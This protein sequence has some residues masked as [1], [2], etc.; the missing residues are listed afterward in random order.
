MSLFKKYKRKVIGGSV[1]FSMGVVVP[2][3]ALLMYTLVSP[4]GDQLRVFIYSLVCAAVAVQ[5][6]PIILFPRLLN[7][8]EK[9]LNDLESGIEISEEFYHK[10]WNR[11]SKMPIW[12]ALIGILQWICGALIVLIPFEM[13]AQTTK[14]QSFYLENTFIFAAL[15]NV[16]LSF[17]F[18]EGTSSFLLQ[19]GAFD[20]ELEDNKKPFYRRL[21]ISIP[22]MISLMIIIMSDVYLMISYKI[23]SNSLEKAYSNQ[24]YNF[25]LSNEAS[26]NVLLANIES[27]LNEIAELPQIQE[28]MVK[29]NYTALTPILRKVYD[30]PSLYLENSIV[31]SVEDG[32]AVLATGLPDGTGIGYKLGTNPNIKENISHALEGKIHFGKVENSPIT[33]KL[34]IMVSAPIKA[35]GKVVGIL[36]LPMRMDDAIQDLLKNIKIGNTGYSF[37]LDR[38]SQ[39]VWHPNPKYLLVK[40]KDTEFETLSE[41]AGDTK[42]FVNNWEGSKFLLR[43]KTSS[44][45]GYQFYS[46]IDLAEI[47]KECYD[48]LDGLVLLSLSGA[49]LIALATFFVFYIKFKPIQGIES[50]LQNM[51]I[52][53]LTQNASLVSSDE[54]GKLAKGLNKT[55]LQV[56][57]VV[58]VNQAISDEMAAAAEQMSASLGSLSINSQTQAASAEEISASIEEISAAVQSVDSQAESQFKKVDYLKQQMNELTNEIQLTGSEVT[59]ATIEFTKITD[60]AKKG[61]LSLDQMQNSISK[62]GESSE[63]IGSVI[64]IINNISEQINLLALNAA[65]EAARAGSYGR[66]FAV[67]ADEIGKLAIKTAS[68]IKDISELIEANDAEISKGTTIIGS[69]I[70]L[71][72][73]IIQ[74]VAS[75]QKVTE[76]IQQSTKHQLSR[77]ASVVS[78]V[79]SVNEISQMIRMSMEEQKQAI[80][81]VAQ[82]I[83]SINDLTQT[84]A[85]GV[86]EMTASSTGIANLSENLRKKINFFQ[87]RA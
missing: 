74:G 82:A 46:T 60:E 50:I 29:K 81:E 84:N 73:N 67:V 71:I 28:A 27:K 4:E 76:S 16:I 59:K 65:I 63:Q 53:N 85:A 45:Y 14:S 80:G 13:H 44:K 58:S 64:E 33:K 79:E 56:S 87:L 10:I 19:Q 20:R 26:M 55:L 52:G 61:Q 15:L 6:F 49:F 23:N 57:E 30:N 48:S 42:A 69:T 66:G 32:Y 2:L 38:D 21:S 68:S 83:F 9:Y 72:Q 35:N 1:G 34:V 78:E 39:M 3:G 17:L 41:E 51:G 8:V 47:E 31:A 86:E 36:G 37:I 43:K 11:V 22:V 5:I 7:D 70:N 54:F 12:L 25:N 18:I 62:I 40:F 77:N 75:F 24:L